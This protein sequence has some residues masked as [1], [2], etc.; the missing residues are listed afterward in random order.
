MRHFYIFNIN[1]EFIEL[2]KKKPYQLFKTFEELYNMPKNEL[3][4]GVNIYDNITLPIN[5]NNISDELFKDYHNNSNYIKFMN[6]H[7]YNDYFKDENTT[8]IIKNAYM[9]LD[10]TTFKPS[11]FNFLNRYKSLF[12]CDFENR[13]YF[14]LESIA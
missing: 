11:F 13:D 8:L 7:L 14:W 1:N 4:Y 5:K 12:A 2:T 10:T 6:T 9:L 3:I